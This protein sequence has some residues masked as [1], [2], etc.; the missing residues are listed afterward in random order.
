[1]TAVE[2]VRR[3]CCL[4]QEE[5]AKILGVTK[6][7]ISNWESEKTHPKRAYILAIQKIDKAYRN[8][9]TV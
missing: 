6:Q 1:M 2:R 9:Y 8:K 7:T 3:K 5:L 4:T